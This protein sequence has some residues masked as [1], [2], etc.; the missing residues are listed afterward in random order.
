MLFKF[1]LA[2][3]SRC[4]AL[5]HDVRDSCQLGWDRQVPSPTRFFLLTFSPSSSSHDDSE[6]T[7]RPAG[8]LRYDHHDHD[9][10]VT[11]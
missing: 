10:C 4:R 5:N 8:L 9:Q 3:P 6:L 2:S 11:V 7:G 1:R